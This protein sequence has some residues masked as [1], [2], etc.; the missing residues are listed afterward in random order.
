[1]SRPYRPWTADD[2]AQLRSLAR[3]GLTQ[4]AIA[5]HMGRERT[6]VCRKMAE[7]GIEPGVSPAHIAALAKINMRMRFAELAA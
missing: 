4:A 6:Q 3:A 2:R 5:E 1:M 7:H